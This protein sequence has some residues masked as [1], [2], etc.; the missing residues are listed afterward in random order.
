MLFD[1]WSLDQIGST[2]STLDNYRKK[3]HV[4]GLDL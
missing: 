1:F 4:L 3:S 2:E